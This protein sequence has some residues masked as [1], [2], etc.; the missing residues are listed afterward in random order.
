MPA[1]PVGAVTLLFTDIES[2]TQLLL[3]LG[4]DHAGVFGCS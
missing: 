1:P 3:D 2:S 4:D